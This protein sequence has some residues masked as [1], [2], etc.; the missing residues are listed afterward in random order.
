MGIWASK[1]GRGFETEKV[2]STSLATFLPPIFP[3]L[4][5]FSSPFLGSGVGFPGGFPGTVGAISEKI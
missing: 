2:K 5:L 4:I 1:T 3:T